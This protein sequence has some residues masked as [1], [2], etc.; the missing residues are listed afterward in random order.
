MVLDHTLQNETM[1]GKKNTYFNFVFD[2]INAT[3]KL[4]T[5]VLLNISW[6]LMHF[7]QS[8]INR[9]YKKWQYVLKYESFLT[10]VNVF[11]V[12][13]DHLM[14][15]C[16]IKVLISFKNLT[17]LTLFKGSVLCMDCI[18]AAHMHT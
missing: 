16:W 17:V 14:H 12:I 13:F 7:L 15:P 1:S 3:H 5:V 6:K 10:S 8:L 4:S 18:H 2:Q 11:T 9:K